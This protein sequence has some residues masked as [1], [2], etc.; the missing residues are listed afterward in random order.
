MRELGAWEVENFFRV[1]RR[2]SRRWD[3]EVK[4]VEC[5]G[6]VLEGTEEERDMKRR[7]TGR[8]ERTRRLGH[9]LTLLYLRE[10][11]GL[12][13]AGWHTLQ[14]KTAHQFK[15][16]LARRRDF[17]GLDTLLAR[18]RVEE[19]QESLVRLDAVVGGLFGDLEGE[20]QGIGRTQC[21]RIRAFCEGNSILN[22]SF[23]YE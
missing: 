18:C 19:T 16:R 23:P 2:G 6:T 15:F 1:Y 17:Y 10:E 11:V 3:V 12:I 9:V 5:R 13:R 4:E 8:R 7:I 14:Y 22:Y 20:L 21:N